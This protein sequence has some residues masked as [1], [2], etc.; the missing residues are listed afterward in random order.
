M[1]N[2]SYVGAE[3]QTIIIQS[4]KDLYPL[5]DWCQTKMIELQEEKEAMRLKYPDD[6]KLEPFKIRIKNK[7]KMESLELE[8]CSIFI[9]KLMDQVEENGFG[10][11]DDIDN[12]EY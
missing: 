11:Q 1:K 6:P 10:N 9:S 7:L 12:I 2:I 5:L 3:G 4:P 8:R